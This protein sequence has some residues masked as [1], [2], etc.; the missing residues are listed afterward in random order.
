MSDPKPQKAATSSRA[1]P[2]GAAAAHRCA[3]CGGADLEPYH[4]QDDREL[5]RCRACRLVFVDPLP[6][7][8]EKAEIERRA[9]AEGLLPELTDFF[10]NC[11][12]D[13]R[14]DPVIDGFRGG[15]AWMGEQREPGKLLDVGPGTGVFLYLAGLE[16]G[17]DPTGIDLCQEAADK[18]E[19]E[20]GV[21][22]D[23]GDFFELDYA[24][25][26]FAAVT[27]LDMLEHTLDPPATL[28]RAY[29][30]LAPG[31]L[32]YVVV[33]NHRCLL[34][35]ILDA[36]IRAGGPLRR[37]FLDRL[38]VAPHVFYFNPRNL[39]RAVEDAGF[40]I[41]GV[42]GGNVYLGR[43]LLPWWM[44]VPMEI[45]LQAGSAVGMHAKIHVLARKPA[46]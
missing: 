4:R 18:A 41:V 22:V 23:V 14:D 43:Y 7:P 9:Y 17:W 40:E 45:V 37:F 46:A 30:L 28:R 25:A 32:L 26:T 11:H 42:R 39:R 3:V 1:A 21:A 24:P 12:R 8:Q 6:S 35:V 2:A 27:M 29:E 31:G 33:P 13:F 38:Y 15:L 34:T 10:A 44:R 20:F 36:W 16:Y 5:V 19:S